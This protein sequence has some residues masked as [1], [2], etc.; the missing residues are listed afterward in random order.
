MTSAKFHKIRQLSWNPADFM[1]SFLDHL[2]MSLC[3]HALSIMCHCHHWHHQCHHQHLCTA[4]PVI[5]L[6]IEASYLA[7]LCKYTLSLCKR[8]IKSMWHVLFKWQPFYQIPLCGS[9]VY[10]I[11]LRAFIFGSVMHLYWSYPRE[12]IMHLLII[13]LKLWILRIFR[14]CTFWLIWHICQ[15]Y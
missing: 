5:A 8:N 3:N 12:E 9:P 7:D 15:R 1:Y 13:F 10:M 4:V 2:V 6:I 11:K 14:F